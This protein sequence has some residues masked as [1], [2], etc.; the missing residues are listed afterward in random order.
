MQFHTVY[1]FNQPFNDNL[2]HKIAQD[3]IKHKWH[4]AILGEMKLANDCAKC[5]LFAQ[6]VTQRKQKIAQ[7]FCERKP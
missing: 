4:S 5:Y 6:N 7:N 1:T 3:R 2:V